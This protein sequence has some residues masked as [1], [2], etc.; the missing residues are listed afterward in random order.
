MNEVYFPYESGPPANRLEMRHQSATLIDD[1]LL[2]SFTRSVNHIAFSH[3]S[4]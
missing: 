2:T 4:F 3:S 1:R